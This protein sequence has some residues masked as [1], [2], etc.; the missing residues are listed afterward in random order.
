M[1]HQSAGITP[2]SG[3]EGI[4]T[5]PDGNLWFTEEVAGKIGRI[6]PHGVVTE[7]SLGITPDREPWNTKGPDGNLW[8]TEINTGK[9]GR[10]TPQGAVTEFQ[11]ARPEGPWWITAGPDGNIWF[12][13]SN[14]IGRITTSGTDESVFAAG[15]DPSAGPWQ[16]TR[17]PDGNL[18]FTDSTN[19]AARIGR[20]TP[21]AWSP[22]SPR[23]SASRHT[24]SRRSAASSGS[25][26]TNKVATASDG[27]SSVTRGCAK[28]KSTRVGGG[29]QL[30][31]SLR[32]PSDIGFLVQR[33]EAGNRVKVG[34]YPLLNHHPEGRLL[35]RWDLKV[36]GHKLPN[37]RYMITLRALDAQSA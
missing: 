11:V 22:S 17:G 25:P 19:T 33:I 30:S 20:I 13:E 21:R 28:A 10:I 34:R 23:A 14:A 5:G 6:T 16:I 32:Q 1:S 15:F 12:T 27:W 18:W 35:L 9:I 37:G 26:R 4:T 7:F 29:E 3:L 24:G 36:D 8:F 2:N 31:S